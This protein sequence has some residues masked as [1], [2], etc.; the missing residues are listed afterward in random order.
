MAV[1]SRF[2]PA[3]K[4]A[5]NAPFA[6]SGPLPAPD[7]I[8]AI[9]SDI[10]RE[11]TSNSLG[12]LP[13]L[14]LTTAATM[15]VNS[16]ASLTLLHSLASYN[17]TSSLQNAAFMREVGLKT[18]SFNGIPRALNQ[19]VHLRATLPTETAE[20]LSTTPTRTLTP[21]SLEQVETRAKGL[22]NSIYDPHSRKLEAKLKAAHPDLPVHILSN[23]YGSLLSD[24]P[25]LHKPA[26]G[27]VLTS[28]VAIACLRA[29]TGV[30]PQVVSH[31]YGLRKGINEGGEE[32][33]EGEK[34]LGGDEG[35]LWALGAV[36]RIVEAIAARRLGQRQSNNSVGAKPVSNSSA[37]HFTTSA[38]CLT[39]QQNPNP[40]QEQSPEQYVSFLTPRQLAKFPLSPLM[41]PIVTSWTAARLKPK[42]PAPLNPTPFQKRLMRNPYAIALSK[43]VRSCALTRTWLPRSFLQPF[44]L[45]PR[46]DTDELWYLPRDLTT[47][48][49]RDE[50]DETETNKRS[51]PGR[52]N[53]VLANQ[54]LLEAVNSKRSG[55][56]GSW[57]RFSNPA[58]GPGPKLRWRADMDEFVC[59][60]MRKKV[61]EEIVA[62]MKWN[63][64][65]ISHAKTWDA[66]V[67][68]KQMG[69][70]LWLGPYTK[71]TDA[72]GPRVDL[73]Q[74]PSTSSPI[75][76]EKGPGPFAT[77]S[78][79]PHW[80]KKLPL[81][82]LVMLLGQEG[83]DSL[84]AQFPNIMCHEF[85]VVK[86]K[87]ETVSVRQW[88]WKLQQFLSKLEDN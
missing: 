80:E 49:P 85:V 65:Q 7:N 18:I 32:V 21:E 17:P 47:R 56:T 3:L 36:D 78:Y 87:Q 14:A 72:P 38:R 5:I 13:W 54:E 81:H 19:L 76:D 45:V 27:R 66:V 16:P 62:L 10:Q 57:A 41:A 88:L 42:L 1:M 15:T 64:G 53:Y 79:P 69:A 77:I 25:G 73:P 4:A 9:Y 22:W 84:R 35:N 68:K 51:R 37:R 82:N 50:R 33:G 34:W 58:V 39:P 28:L 74:A 11:A 40:P 12:V 59:K 6:R 46:P 48:V 20:Q 23:H 30:G 75:T 61:E 44:E 8:T 71:E 24:F 83:V 55:M 67:K 26:V 2:S 86:D 43:P 31:I 63:Q 29:Q 52:R 70:L 60:M